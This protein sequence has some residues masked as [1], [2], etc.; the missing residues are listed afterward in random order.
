MEDTEELWRKHVVKDFKVTKL[1]SE[2]TWR[3][4]YRVRLGRGRG[5]VERERKKKEARE[6]KRGGGVGFPCFLWRL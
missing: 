5:E 3:E 6:G 1:P 4:L 2:Y